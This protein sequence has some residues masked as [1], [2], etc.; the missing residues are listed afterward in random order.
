ML[1]VLGVCWA[2]CICLCV[3]FIHVFWKL[4]NL[5]IIKKNISLFFFSLPF[6]VDNYIY[7]RLLKVVPVLFSLLLFLYFFLSVLIWI[8]STAM[9]SSSLHFIM[10]CLIN[11]LINYVF[12]N[13][14]IAVFLSRSFIF[15]FLNLSP[16]FLSIQH[17]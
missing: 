15:V 6:D 5:D 1:L 11:C 17:S 13:P 8:I 12:F 14:N 10:Q 9:Y 4:E 7:S 3:Y 2:S 16:K